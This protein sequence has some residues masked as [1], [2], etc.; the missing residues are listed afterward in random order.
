ME[1][2]VFYSLRSI[3][4]TVR[5]RRDVAQGDGEFSGMDESESIHRALLIAAILAVV[6]IFA[7][8]NMK[9]SSRVCPCIRRCAFPMQK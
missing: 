6:I 9:P 4:G 5:C 7:A 2:K 1:Y 8:Q 3:G